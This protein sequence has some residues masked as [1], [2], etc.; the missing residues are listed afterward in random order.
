MILHTV[1]KGVCK[2]NIYVGISFF[3]CKSAR[4]AVSVQNENGEIS[5]PPKL[6]IPDEGERLTYDV[7]CF[8]ALFHTL[9]DICRN[10][11]VQQKINVCYYSGSDPL[12]F[13]WEKEYKR[14]GNVGRSEIR[15]KNWDELINLTKEN[16]IMLNIAGKDSVFALAAKKERRR[17]GN[18]S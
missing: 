4:Y 13:S 14:S 12:A 18:E 2:L 11:P 16:N 17:A 10:K 6:F 3:S 15:R 5:F 7:I 1:R 9:I 8:R